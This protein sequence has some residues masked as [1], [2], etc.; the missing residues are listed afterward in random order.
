MKLVMM[1]PAFKLLLLIV[2]IYVDPSETI[3]WKYE[4]V[5]V[6]DK[7]STGMFC[8]LFRQHVIVKEQY[9]P[10]KRA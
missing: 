9:G 10:E 8:V 6:F 5:S 2:E 7:V 4:S 1:L 3:M